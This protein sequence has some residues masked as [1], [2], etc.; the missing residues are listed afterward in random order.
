MS[1]VSNPSVAETS[2]W[3]DYLPVTGPDLPPR[4]GLLADV[5]VARNGL[6]LRTEREGIADALIRLTPSPGAPVPGLEVAL[7]P[8]VRLACPRIPAALFASALETAQDEAR[9]E[10]P[11]EVLCHFTWRPDPGIWEL[12][13]PPQEQSETHCLPLETGPDSSYA[14][15]L[16]DLH[17]HHVWRPFFSAHDTADEQDIRFYAVLGQVLEWPTV[18]LRLGVWG[19]YL[20][21]RAT[22]LFDLPAGV[23]DGATDASAEPA[24]V[25]PCSTDLPMTP[26]S[27]PMDGGGAVSP[28]G[29][30]AM[31]V[32][33]WASLVAGVAD[34]RW[35]MGG[36]R[37]WRAWWARLSSPAEGGGE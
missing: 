33:R 23:L 7:D 2:R 9:G 18:R 13:V 16:C 21:L 30:P 31:L 4:S 22:T 27:V 24:D 17:S 20:Y 12:H 15:A 29:L 6:F 3:I 1:Y 32:R 26:P 34:A 28:E 25:D 36:T 14:A 37:S 8:Y 19:H 5:L 35:P 11:R 10:P